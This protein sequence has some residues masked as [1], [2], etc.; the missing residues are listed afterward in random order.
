LVERE[1]ERERE[2][3]GV[4]ER[5][6][7]MELSRTRRTLRLFGALVLA[8]VP[9]FLFSWKRGFDSVVLTLSTGLYWF[10]VSIVLVDRQWAWV[11][12]GLVLVFVSEVRAARLCM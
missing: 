3:A 1:R 7:E 5:S 4:R 11:D 12:D 10:L 9:S 6:R 8:S 2:R